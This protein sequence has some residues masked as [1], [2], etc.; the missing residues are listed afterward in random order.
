MAAL[1]SYCSSDSS[2]GDGD[3]AVADKVRPRII[4]LSHF[5]REFRYRILHQKRTKSKKRRNRKGDIARDLGDNRRHLRRRN[6]EGEAEVRRGIV[7][8]VVVDPDRAREI[9]NDDEGD[10]RRR[11]RD[12]DRES[13]ADEDQARESVVGEDRDRESVAGTTTTI[14][15][16][17]VVIVRRTN[18]KPKRRSVSFCGL[19]KRTRQRIDF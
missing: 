10:E 19:T 7:V 16:A 15:F 1:V 2:D 5:V 12:R 13:V 3:G 11:N 18:V 14:T 8:V 4:N 17:I 9:A 6:D